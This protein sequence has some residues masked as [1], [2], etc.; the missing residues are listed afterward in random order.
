M[1]LQNI[2]QICVAYLL[3]SAPEQDCMFPYGAKRNIAYLPGQAREGSQ[4][5]MR[6]HPYPYPYPY[7]AASKR[8]DGGVNSGMVAWPCAEM[9]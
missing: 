2:A 1:A 5:Q 3:Q 6:E 9:P 8:G 4:L 7:S